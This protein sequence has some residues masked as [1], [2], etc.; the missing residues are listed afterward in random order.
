M[1]RKIESLITSKTKLIIPVHYAG[2]SLDLDPIYQL[3]EKHSIPVVEDAAHAL[4]TEYKGKPVGNRVHA[5]SLLTQSK[6]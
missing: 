3:G 4:G 6:T 5:Y 2:A 1:L